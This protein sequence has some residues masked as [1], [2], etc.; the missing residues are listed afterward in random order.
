M[1]QIVFIANA[2]SALLGLPPDRE[3]ALM[4]AN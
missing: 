2:R 1:A 3:V 4:L